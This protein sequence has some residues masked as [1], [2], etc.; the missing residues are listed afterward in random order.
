M[1]AI[2]VEIFKLL[3]KKF[4]EIDSFQYLYN[5]V[6]LKLLTNILSASFIICSIKS[7]HVRTRYFIDCMQFSIT[8]AL[9]NTFSYYKSRQKGTFYT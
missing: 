7:F 3:V 6:T 2:P 4:P 9:F 5:K 1:N 8:I